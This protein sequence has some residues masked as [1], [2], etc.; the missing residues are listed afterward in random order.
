MVGEHVFPQTE[1]VGLLAHITVSKIN[2][3]DTNWQSCSTVVYDKLAVTS[4][5][6]LITGHSPLL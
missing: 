5:D 1:F 6:V 3:L 2:K 4:D